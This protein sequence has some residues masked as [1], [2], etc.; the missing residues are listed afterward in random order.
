MCIQASH[1]TNRFY[2]LAR[3]GRREENLI[4]LISDV[5]YGRWAEWISDGVMPHP[6]CRVAGRHGP[7][8]LVEYHGPARGPSAGQAGPS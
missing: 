1:Q 6:T 8:R 2:A 4:L 3:C 7:A 5:G